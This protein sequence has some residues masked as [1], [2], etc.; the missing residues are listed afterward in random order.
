L[1]WYRETFVRGAIDVANFDI[2]WVGGL[3]EAQRIA[4]LATAFD[5]MIAPHDCTGPV[6]L[7]AN[8]HLLVACP[9]GLIAET[10][11]AHTEGFYKKIVTAL[12]PIHRGMI[13]PTETTGV[14]AELSPEFLARPDLNRRLTGSSAG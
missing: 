12:P 2:A 3:G 11:R 10:V 9:N 14:G 6:T 8:V 5:R 13:S 7:L 4:H 1:Q